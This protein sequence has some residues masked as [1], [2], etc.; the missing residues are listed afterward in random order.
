MTIQRINLG[1]QV[2]DGLGDDLRTAFEKVNANFT[3]LN[4][5]LTVTASNIGG[6]GYGV[7]NKKVNNNLEFKNIV[8]GRGIA[9]DA[10][11]TSLIINSVAPTA[12]SKV[13]PTSGSSITATPDNLGQININGGSNINVSGSGSTLT[14]DTNINLNQV[15]LNLDFGPISDQFVNPTQLALAAANVDMGTFENPG[16]LSLDLG[17]II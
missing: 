9:I 11:P 3:E 7:F 2:N 8:P 13:V 5:Q 10:Q 1:N 15:L 6:T 16:R 12:F 4:S 14:I 17:T